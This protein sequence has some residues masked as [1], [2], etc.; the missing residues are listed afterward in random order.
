MDSI[1]ADA[2]HRRAPKQLTTNLCGAFGH[3]AMQ[4]RPPCSKPESAGRKQSICRQ[5]A[6]QKPDALKPIRLRK[7]QLKAKPLQ[8]SKPIRHQAFSARLVDW[9]L[10]AIRDGHAKSSLSRRDGHSQSCGSTAN[11]ENVR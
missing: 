3:Y 10:P 6:T 7:R 9:R 2:R 5:L 1:R 4:D 8:C 11:H